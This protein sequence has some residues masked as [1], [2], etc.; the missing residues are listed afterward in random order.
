[1]R[2][3][4]D[5]LRVADARYLGLTWAQYATLAMTLAGLFLLRRLSARAE[6]AAR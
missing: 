2:F 5:F 6:G 4:L 3:G 1:M